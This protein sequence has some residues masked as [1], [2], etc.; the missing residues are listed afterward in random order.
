MSY[1]VYRLCVCRRWRHNLDNLLWLRP[2]VLFPVDSVCSS[3][4]LSLVFVFVY[5]FIFYHAYVQTFMLTKSP[6][7]GLLTIYHPLLNF[8]TA[9]IKAISVLRLEFCGWTNQLLFNILEIN[10]YNEDV[11][12]CVRL[13]HT[14]LHRHFIIDMILI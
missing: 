8:C 13:G 14:I 10:K 5:I 1:W 9:F 6:F 2:V 12:S 11:Q 4:R 7:L 3:Y